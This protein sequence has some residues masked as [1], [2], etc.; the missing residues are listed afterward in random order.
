[1]NESHFPILSL[2]IFLPLLG[3]LMTGLCGNI[4]LAKK[5]ALAF[6]SL[7][8]I[9]SLWALQRFQ[10]SNGDFQL[11]ERTEWIPSLHIEFL[12]GIDGISVLFLPLSALLTLMAMIASWNSIQHLSRLHFALLLVLEGVT[13]GVFCALD[14]VLFFLFWELTLPPLFFLIG[15]WG[16]GPARRS[17]AMKYTLFMLFGGVPL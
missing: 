13:I 1:M 12:L 9:A 2:L 16:I 17:A 11:L 8:L 14:M 3:A 5:V 4:G 7:E 15:L 10:S 6:A